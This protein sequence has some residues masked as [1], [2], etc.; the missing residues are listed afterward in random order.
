LADFVLQNRQP[1]VSLRC[2][3]R[4]K[5]LTPSQAFVRLLR[6]L[7]GPNMFPTTSPAYSRD[8]LVTLQTKV[9]SPTSERHIMANQNHDTTRGGTHEQHVKA[10]EQSH[11]NSGSSAGSAGGGAS[12]SSGSARGGSHEQHAKAGEQ[13]HK[14]ER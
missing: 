5:I 12:Q 10:G 6:L 13:S 3:L 7:A 8:M 14:N 2:R 11:K 4:Q 1:Y 9:F